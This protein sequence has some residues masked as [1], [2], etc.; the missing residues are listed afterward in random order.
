[1][2]SFCGFI[3]FQKSK[4]VLRITRRFVNLISTKASHNNIFIVPLQY[5]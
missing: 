2:F 5:L 3:Y 4:L 1:M